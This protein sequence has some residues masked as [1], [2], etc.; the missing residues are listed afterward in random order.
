MKS[1]DREVERETQVEKERGAESER[2]RQQGRLSEGVE[3]MT[4]R[5]AGRKK[6]REGV[7]WSETRRDRESRRERERGRWAGKQQI[8]RDHPKSYPDLQNRI[9]TSSEMVRFGPEFRHFDPGLST[10]RR[11]IRWFA[12]RSV[13]IPAQ[14]GEIPV[15]TGLFLTKFRYDSEE[16]DTIL[17]GPAINGCARI[18][19]PL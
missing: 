2:G 7:E 9:W 14:N 17:D 1:R 13:E 19:P 5:E 8:W 11:A 15:Q 6:V 10:L 12:R 3:W 4:G 18:A 16:P